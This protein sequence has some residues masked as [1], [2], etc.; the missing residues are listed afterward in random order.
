MAPYPAQLKVLLLAR[1]VTD[2]SYLEDL[3]ERCSMNY[4]ALIRKRNTGHYLILT[5]LYLQ[6]VVDQH[7]LVG[8]RIRSVHIVTA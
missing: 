3:Q 8:Q 6:Q 1:L 2:V 7:P 5:I 4:A